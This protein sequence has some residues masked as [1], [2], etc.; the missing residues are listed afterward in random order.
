MV[1]R[2]EIHPQHNTNNLAPT[3]GYIY[4]RNGSSSW[5]VISNWTD[6]QSA[7][8]NEAMTIF[9]N[10]YGKAYEEFALVGTKRYGGDGGSIGVG[11]F[12]LYGH[13][14]NDPG[15]LPII[16]PTFSSIRTLR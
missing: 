4:G 14:E 2:F 10:I 3:S 5:E 16:P 13:R 12:Q 8:A 1:S 9:P 6:L 7:T 15:S 11:E